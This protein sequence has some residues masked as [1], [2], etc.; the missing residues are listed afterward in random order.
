MNLLP[1]SSY[2][3]RFATKF[4]KFNANSDVISINLDD[5]NTTLTGIYFA[6]SKKEFK[7][8]QKSDSAFIYYPQKGWL[9]FNENGGAKKYGDGGLV[10]RFAKKTRLNDKNFDFNGGFN[11]TPTPDPTK[12]K[13]QYSITADKTSV[14]EGDRVKWTI[15]TQNVPKGTRIFFSDEYE[16]STNYADYYSKMDG[17][18]INSDGEEKF[19]FTTIQN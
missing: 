16:N 9:Y 1:P 5:F 3:K 15:N 17:T 6:N 12:V 19:Y 10:A 4:K 18:A 11:S 7:K 8:A 14:K 13:A 2:S